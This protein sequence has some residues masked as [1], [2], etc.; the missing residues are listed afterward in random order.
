MFIHNRISIPNHHHHHRIDIT[1]KTLRM[2]RWQRRRTLATTNRSPSRFNTQCGILRRIR[3][4]PQAAH[5]LVVLLRIT[6]SMDM[7]TTDNSFGLCFY[8]SFGA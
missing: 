8:F 1:T 7:A 6:R 2:N 4:P 3:T 5:H